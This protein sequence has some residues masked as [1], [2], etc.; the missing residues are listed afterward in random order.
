MSSTM[1]RRACAGV[2][3]VA[4]AVALSGCAET[5]G[6]PSAQTTT[7]P[8]PNVQNQKAVPSVPGAQNAADKV[9]EQN[10]KLQGVQDD[11][12]ALEGNE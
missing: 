10:A 2:M 5:T 8:V 12:D 1:R 7:A 4:L 9:N 6:A 3:M 11:I